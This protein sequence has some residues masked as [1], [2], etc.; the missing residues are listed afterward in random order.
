VL[1]DTVNIAKRMEESAEPGTLIVSEATYQ[2]IQGAFQ[3][4]RL[5]PV[6]LLGTK[7]LVNIFQ[8]LDELQ[9]PTKL[10]YRNKGG[11]E[12]NLVGRENE[13]EK[14]AELFQITEENNK[15]QLVL[16]SGDVGVGKSRLLFEFAGYLETQNPLLTVMSS[17]ALEQTSRVPY[18]LW[19]ELWANRFELNED[20][21]LDVS[22]KKIID[23]IR[24]FWGRSLGEVTAVEAAHFLGSLIGIRWEKSRFLD[25]FITNPKLRI[26]RAFLMLEELF[27]RVSMRGPLV[28]ILDDLQWADPGSLALIRHLW[29]SAKKEIPLLI[30]T[31]A[32][33]EFLLGED[34]EFQNA[35]RIELS[36]LSLNPEIVR[37]AYPALRNSPDG[38][39]NTLA[40]K[41]TGNPYFLEELVK[42]VL[43][44]GGKAEEVLDK[45]PDSLDDLLK[46]RLDS[47]S[48]EGRATAYFAA[49]AGRVFW[50]GS[51]MAAFRGSPGV[52]Q[53]LE[54]SSHNLVGKVQ[55]A[56]DEM[57][58]KELA[59]L[60]V[61]S[62]FSG[63]REYIFKHSRLHE[64]ALSRLPDE[65]QETCNLALG[66]WL[67]ERAGPERSIC[68]AQHFE[69][70]G[71]FDRAQEFYT[72]AADHA[73]SVGS[74]EEADDI[75]YYARTLPE[76]RLTR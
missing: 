36:S 41:S 75:Q 74:D 13:M 52:T 54:V 49:I 20:D 53:V 71:I 27:S 47:L 72:I 45:L 39:L 33:N 23:A 50:K 61:G 43:P 19:K 17:R 48:I 70:A 30:L 25:P 76:D 1:G 44:Y 11:L 31:S 14:L 6:Q 37:R 46:Y 9:Q 42:L 32:R 22:Q 21:P 59:F 8:I 26:E 51:V 2:S 40:E 4:K 73:R 60:R 7:A 56:L 57:M 35:E 16:V 34:Q 63:E 24:T 38:M 62:A 3:V 28:L 12:T 66:L 29:Q 10:R 5:T 67:A 18:G 64:V 58:E 55:K 68:V 65:L 15:P 69:K